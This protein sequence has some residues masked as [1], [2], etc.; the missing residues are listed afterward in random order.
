MSLADDLPRPC[1]ETPPSRR[2]RPTTVED[3]D[4]DIVPRW[5]H[6]LMDGLDDGESSRASLSR[7]SQRSRSSST[8]S[9]RSSR[10]TDGESPSTIAPGDSVSNVGTAAESCKPSCMYVACLCV[11]VCVRVRVCVCV[12]VR[13]TIC[14]YIKFFM[15]HCHVH[16]ACSVYMYN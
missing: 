1:D 12:R 8:N 14:E 4:D 9:G 2:S 11:C 7:A 6:D 16:A 13:D 3:S 15:K 10:M 5:Q